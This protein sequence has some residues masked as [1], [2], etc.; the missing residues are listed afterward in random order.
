MCLH[1]KCVQNP[2]LTQLAVLQLSPICGLSKIPRLHP[3]AGR[4]MTLIWFIGLAP[5][6]LA[7]RQRAPRPGLH[8]RSLICTFSPIEVLKGRQMCV[9]LRRKCTKVGQKCYSCA[10]KCAFSSISSKCWLHYHF[11][12]NYSWGQIHIAADERSSECQTI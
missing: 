2:D 12:S 6:W 11:D 10:R 9:N 4:L 1:A 3:T 8:N 5:T 7:V